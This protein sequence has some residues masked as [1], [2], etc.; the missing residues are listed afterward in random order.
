MRTIEDIRALFPQPRVAPGSQN[1]KALGYCVGGAL[2]R[3]QHQD[4]KSPIMQ[5]INFP[6]VGF[7]KEV[8]QELNPTLM[9]HG[10]RLYARE[11]IEFNDAGQFEQAWAVTARALSQGK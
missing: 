10:A 4:I 1:P 6:S 8:L 11:I 2:C 5:A 3:F 7:L 9:S